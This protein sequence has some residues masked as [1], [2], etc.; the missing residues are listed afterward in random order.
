MKEK[1]INAEQAAELIFELVKAKPWL[2]QPGVMLSSDAAAEHEAVG[3]L[4]A[5]DSTTTGWGNTSLSGRRVACTMVVDFL[6]KLMHP[7][8]PYRNRQ[9]HV[10]AE[11]SRQDQALHVICA[12]IRGSHP[13]RT[14]MQ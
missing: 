8:S 12:E 11:A 4:L 3:F 5:L 7:D 13:G 1:M 9:W 10:A 6:G 2:N 14:A